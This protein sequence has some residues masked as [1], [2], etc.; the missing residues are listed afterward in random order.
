MTEELSLRDL[1]I[2]RLRT[3][4]TRNPTGRARRIAK[5]AAMTDEEFAAYESARISTVARMVAEVTKKTG[6]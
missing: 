3:A 4:P 2:A 1:E 6:R 5:I